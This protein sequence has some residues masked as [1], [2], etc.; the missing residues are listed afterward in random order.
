MTT[1]SLAFDPAFIKPILA[2]EKTL[3][4]RY[5]LDDDLEAGVPIDLIAEYSGELIDRTVCLYVARAPADAFA[6]VDLPGHRSY[7][8]TDE[9]LDELGRYY[10]EADLT[11]ATELAAVLWTH[12]IRGRSFWDL[13]GEQA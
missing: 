7:A 2:G 1:V 5:D 3:T 12:S 13:R 11:P 8:D 4:L 9:L 10:P 6:G